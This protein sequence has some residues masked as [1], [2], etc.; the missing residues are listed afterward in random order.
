MF[1][2]KV[3][4]KITQ[5]Y[6]NLFYESIQR[7][8]KAVAN[9]Q[10]GHTNYLMYILHRIC[11]IYWIN[12]LS[13]KGDKFLIYIPGHQPEMPDSVKL[14]PRDA[15]YLGFH[16]DCLLKSID[17]RFLYQNFIKIGQVVQ[18]LQVFEVK[19]NFLSMAEFSIKIMKESVFK[20]F[21]FFNSLSLGTC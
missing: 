4:K 17:W 1:T 21:S 7:R 9:A 15:T 18:I 10:K 19:T 12:R 13:Q 5:F 3:W 2:L 16:T 6:I 14:L 11:I 8:M 20:F